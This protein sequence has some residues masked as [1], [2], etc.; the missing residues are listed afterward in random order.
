MSLRVKFLQFHS[1]APFFSFQK[2]EL[3]LSAVSCGPLSSTPR[4]AA[5]FGRMNQ[6]SDQPVG[7]CSACPSVGPSSPVVQHGLISVSFPQC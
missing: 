5:A 3:V 1:H 7:E 4:F 2:Q 6:D